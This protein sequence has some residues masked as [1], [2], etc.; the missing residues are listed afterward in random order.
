VV[1]EL[2]VDVQV[3]GLVLSEHMVQ[4]GGTAELK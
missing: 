1:I 2:A 4:T 3:A